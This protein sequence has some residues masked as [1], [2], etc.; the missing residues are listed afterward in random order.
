MVS[1][2]AWQRAGFHQV[3]VPELP[4]NTGPSTSIYKPVRVSISGDAHWRLAR[5]A[6]TYDLS[7]R[8][9]LERMIHHG[10][11]GMNR[12]GSWEA[13]TPFDPDMYGPDSVADTWFQ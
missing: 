12:P 7:V 10:L 3:H 11:S 1:V 2:M 9:L 5:L 4:I 8:D 6:M 13:V